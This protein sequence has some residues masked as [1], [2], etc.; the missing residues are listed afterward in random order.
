MIRNFL[1][2]T[3]HN[4]WIESY[5]HTERTFCYELYHQL[6]IN[7]TNYQNELNL[8]NIIISGE[9]TKNA[10]DGGSWTSPDIVLHNDNNHDNEDITNQ[11]LVIEVKKYGRSN[12]SIKKD[13][14]KIHDY[15]TTLNYQYGVILLCDKNSQEE[16]N[17]IN[18]IDRV[19]TE[20]DENGET[21]NERFNIVLQNND[22]RLFF[23]LVTSGHNN[24]I[25]LEFSP[26]N[27]NDA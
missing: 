19:L 15:M 2:T 25:L 18:K 5:F 20:P 24:V 3:C 23:I 7:L 21:F 9:I 8:N 11:F 13:L 10:Q 17:F 22:K 14:R 6:K 1:D 16:N 27:N 26:N 4:I 12:I